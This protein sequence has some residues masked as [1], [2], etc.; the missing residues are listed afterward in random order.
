MNPILSRAALAAIPFVLAG[1]AEA[2]FA[3]PVV[4]DF[5]AGASQWFDGANAALADWHATGGV[6]DGAYVS[7]TALIPDPAPPFG[8]TLFRGHA[9]NGA[10]GG[11]FVGDWI[12]AGATEFRF[13]VRHD[14]PAPATFFARFATP[15]NFPGAAGLSFVPVAP[16]VWTEIV[17]DVTEGSDQIVLEDTYAGVFSNVG[18]LQ[19]GFT[20]SEPFLGGS[21]TFDLDRVSVVPTPAAAW[22]FLSLG[23]VG[24]RRRRR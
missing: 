23:L 21:F 8:S 2:G 7:T 20:P 15:F 19:I 12:A 18:N 5:D 17:I 16:G 4:E 10:S 3:L 24:A 13:W 9:A 6:D 22:A 11:A 14:G 1:A